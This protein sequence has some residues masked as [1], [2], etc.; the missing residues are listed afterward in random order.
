MINNLISGVTFLC[1]MAILPAQ[2]QAVVYTASTER[3]AEAVVQG[4]E[5]SL[6]D[7]KFANT[8]LPNSMMKPKLNDPSDHYFGSSPLKT[9]ALIGIIG[10]SSTPKI[11]TIIFNSPIYHWHCG[12]TI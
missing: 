10:T 7:P 12:L 3:E 1:L 2:A 6:A 5:L 9:R 11:R 8:S 4:V